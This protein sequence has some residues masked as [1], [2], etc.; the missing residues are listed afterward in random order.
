[1]G[2]SSRSSV[3][4][5]ATTASSSAVEAA[6]SWEW[7]S[8]YYIPR[9]TEDQEALLDI[10]IAEIQQ[11]QPTCSSVSIKEGRS[12]AWR[13]MEGA[14]WRLEPVRGKRVSTF[15]L[16]TLKWREREDVD[17][18]LDVRRAHEMFAGEAA[19]GKLFVRGSCLHG[20]PLIWVHLGREN[21]ALDPEANVKFL[22][23][24][25]VSFGVKVSLGCLYITKYLY[26]LIN[27]KYFEVLYGGYRED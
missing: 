21:N 24:T 1:M 11:Q 18:V 14:Q 6:Q 3:M 20:R 23:Y 15:F 7:D 27:T 12:A 19:T 16:E 25:V 2:V 9:L 10:T 8:C 22:V 13:Y 26:Y 5:T 17:S 4:D